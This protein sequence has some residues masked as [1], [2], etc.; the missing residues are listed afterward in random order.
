MKTILKVALIFVLLLGFISC[1][2]DNLNAPVKKITNSSSS[3]DPGEMHN[4]ILLQYYDTY[5]TDEDMTDYSKLTSRLY[6]I[7]SKIQPDLYRSVDS[8]QVVD[9]V[10][11]LLGKNGE[12]FQYRET[13]GNMLDIGIQ[14]KI[15]STNFKDF[16]IFDI[17]DSN[18]SVA[19]TLEKVEGYKKKNGTTKEEKELL[20][21]FQ[22]V[23]VSSDY[24]WNNYDPYEIY[25]A[26]G[27]STTGCNPVHQVVIADSVAS[28]VG[29]LTGFF[30]GFGVGGVFLSTAFS[31]GTSALVRSIQNQTENGG[32]I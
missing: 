1:S 10:A 28:I 27:Y 17:I 9:G 18:E 7:G 19:K 2:N 3:F 4:N 23:L 25:N 32:C 5:G 20:N 11:S 29:G 31:A 15:I 26:P 22:S 30:G 13:I 16:I 14:E 6:H 24:F 8:T 12:E 21:I